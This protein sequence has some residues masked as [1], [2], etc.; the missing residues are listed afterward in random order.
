MEYNFNPKDQSDLKLVA[1]N[2]GWRFR[3]ARAR[4]QA[5]AEAAAQQQPVAARCKDREET[6][7][8]KKAITREKATKPKVRGT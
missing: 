8:A 4:L 6:P 7:P 2:A 5:A 3:G 1:P